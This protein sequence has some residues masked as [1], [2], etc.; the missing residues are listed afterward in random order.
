MSEKEEDNE[1]K[2]IQKITLQPKGLMLWSKK[3]F[4]QQ[5]KTDVVYLDAT[6]SVVKKKTKDRVHL[7]TY[8][9]LL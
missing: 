3:D 2:L 9:N 7:F 6:G 5:S 1:E 8:M 4:H